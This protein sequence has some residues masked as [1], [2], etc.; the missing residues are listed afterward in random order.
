MMTVDHG[1]LILPSRASALADA[2]RLVDEYARRAGFS[3]IDRAEI[4]LAANEAVS[5]AM[6]HGSPAGEADHVELLVEVEG[7][8]L[9]VTVRDHGSPD[10]LPSPSLPDPTEYANNGRGVFLMCQM[11][12]EVEFMRDGGTVVRMSKQRR[13]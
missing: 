7:P 10:R 13:A 8:R 3:D 5:N 12:D 9:V 2:R 6:R 11:M 1:T 4:V